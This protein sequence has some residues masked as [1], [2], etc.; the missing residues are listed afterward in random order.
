M[1]PG[2][3]PFTQP[4]SSAADHLYLPPMMISKGKLTYAALVTYLLMP[5]ITSFMLVLPLATGGLFG[6]FMLVFFPFVAIQT[7]KEAP[8]TIGADRCQTGRIGAVRCS[9]PGVLLHRQPKECSSIARRDFQ[10]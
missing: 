2:I 8:S 7:V 1:C 9:I 6:L 3:D 10:I 5:V 4:L